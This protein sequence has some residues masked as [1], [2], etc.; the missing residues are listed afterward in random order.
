MCSFILDLGPVAKDALRFT[1]DFGLVM[2][3]FCC[4]FVIGAYK[5][6][7]SLFPDLVNNLRI[8]EAVARLMLELSSSNPGPAQYGRMILTR[9]ENIQHTIDLRD[10]DADLEQAGTPFS[11]TFIA[12]LE[13]A[14]LADNFWGLPMLSQ[15][16][17]LYE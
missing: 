8:V 11:G 17:Q 6:F 5:T 7:S 3:A 14:F 16:S 12:G 2:V 10:F 9:L 15:D 13:D 1:A 4:T